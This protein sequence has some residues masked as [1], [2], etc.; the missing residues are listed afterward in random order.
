VKGNPFVQ[1]EIKPATI[2]R[3]AYG[4]YP[5]LA[6]LAGMQLDVFS[7]LKDGPMTTAAL[8]N[9]L[10]VQHDKLRPLLYALVHAGLLDLVD[11]DRFGN[12]PEAAMYL[13]RGR[14]AYLG[15]SHELYSDLW[16]A[17]LTAGQSIRAGRPQAKHDFRTMS[18]EELG[19]FFRGL[20]AG[21]LAAGRQ[22]ATAYNFERFR[23]LLDVG[24]GSGGLAIAACQ[25][26]GDLRATVVE[27]PRV[28]SIA[29][30][31][32]RESKLAERVQVMVTDVQAYRRGGSM[33]RCS[34]ALFRSWDEMLPVAY[35]AMWAKQSI[36]VA[37]CSSLVMF[38][39][40][41]A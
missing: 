37:G 33:W 8:A 11:G 25:Q 41:I 23:N 32:V 13:V 17:A 10:A 18:D 4:I 35:F 24:G 3:H 2:F 34:V 15:S 19:A 16:G 1:P 26:C 31:M 14:Q 20:H 29:Q 12:T 9:A 6:M 40:T 7:P 38:S 5:S 21:A 27:L 30:A 36:G 39:K 22:L 28:A